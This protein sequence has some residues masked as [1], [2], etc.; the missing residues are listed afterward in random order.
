[1]NNPL[2]AI[3]NVLFLLEQ[4]ENLSPQG[5]QDLKVI[6]SEAERMA[7]LLNRL[8]ATY[9]PIYSDEIEEI[10]LN[11]IIEDIHSLTSTHM[12]HGE[13]T[14]EFHP[15]SDLPPIRGVSDQI[16]QVVLNLFINAIEAMQ[17]GGHLMVCTQL[18]SGGEQALL[19]VTDTGNGIHPEDLP[20]IFDA[21]FTTKKTG[22]GL[23]LS[24]TSDII[25]QHG[26]EIQ[27]ENNQQSGATFKVWF[28][29]ESR[30]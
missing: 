28:P 29:V 9:R 16:R 20:R 23:G 21:F 7:T 2:Q 14:F 22:T 30:A 24:I 26:G 1:L 11:D 15:D 8:R 3:Q 27:V 25:H 13:I 5:E 19:T 17:T 6:L 18:C 4:D 10:Q 12:R